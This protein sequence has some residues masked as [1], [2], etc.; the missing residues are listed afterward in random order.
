MTLIF[1]VTGSIVEKRRADMGA[2]LR[3]AD[4]RTEDGRHQCCY[5]RRLIGATRRPTNALPC[6]A[7]FL[8]VNSQV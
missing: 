8:R 6:A 5:G 1:G 2:R 4:A 7:R 3:Q